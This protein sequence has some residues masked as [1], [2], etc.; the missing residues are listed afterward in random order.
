M[1]NKSLNMGFVSSLKTGLVETDDTLHDGCHLILIVF[2][3][4]PH[5]TMAMIQEVG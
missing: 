2:A 1:T 5:S 4:N 3:V